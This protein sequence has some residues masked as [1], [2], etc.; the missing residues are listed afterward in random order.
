M[1]RYSASQRVLFK[2][3]N[4]KWQ[5]FVRAL[6]VPY[7]KSICPFFLLKYYKDHTNPADR[8]LFQMH[9]QYSGC[10]DHCSADQR[11]CTKFHQPG[12]RHRFNMSIIFFADLS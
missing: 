11:Q 10:V 12:Y 9:L 3:S 5:T 7:S 8:G 6:L 2:K 4:I 1:R